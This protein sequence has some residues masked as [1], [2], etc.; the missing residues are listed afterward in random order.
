M[1]PPQWRG[2]LSS[3]YLFIKTNKFWREEFPFNHNNKTINNLALNTLC[4]LLGFI[5]MY[6]SARYH[7]LQLPTNIAE[8]FK[9][10]GFSLNHHA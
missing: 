8:L 10:E 6:I 1:G 2:V 5:W 4:R 3:P 9:T 7:N